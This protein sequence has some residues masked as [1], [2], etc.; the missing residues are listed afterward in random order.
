MGTAKPPGE[1]E[2]TTKRM[3]SRKSIVIGLLLVG[4]LGVAIAAAATR[5]RTIP[6]SRFRVIAEYPHDPKA[7]TQGLVYHDG[8]LY[9]GTGLEGQSSLRRVELQT[10][11]VAAR[12]DLDQP[13]FG[14]GIAVLD[15]KIYQLTWRNR[16][17][18]VYDAETMQ[19]QKTIR[20][21]GEGWG[22]TSDDEQLILSDGSATLKFLNPATFEVTRRLTVK[23]AKKLVN[24]LNELE[25]VDGEIWANIW[26]S[27]RIARI[28]PETGE[29]VGW[30]D[31]S[32]LW[33]LRDRPSKEYVL[34]GIAYDGEKR[35]FVTGKNW[36]KLY[37]IEVVK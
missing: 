31:L 33:P 11:D 25:Y 13:Y 28:S 12:M 20:Y 24:N 34:N 18:I 8:T 1:A 15:R 35:I 3:M 10:G 2:R 7:F 9:E 23:A 30:I 27:D 29:V 6:V 37:E 26:H 16:L 5:E 32:A 4:A 19:F 17:A 14:E 21:A 36:P 22:L